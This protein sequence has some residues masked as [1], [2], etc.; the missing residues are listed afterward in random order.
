MSAKLKLPTKA[1]VVSRS[2]ACGEKQ[3]V[4]VSLGPLRWT[5][6]QY[7]NTGSHSVAQAS[8]KHSAILLLHPPTSWEYRHDHHTRLQNVLHI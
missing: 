6:T 4:S 5:S 7:Q 3:T 2:K 1:P 8:L